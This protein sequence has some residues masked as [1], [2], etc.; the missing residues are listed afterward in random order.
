METVK[1]YY[2]NAYT[3]DFVGKV[4]SCEP[5]G[6]TLPWCWKVLTFTPKA[7]DSLRISAHWAVQR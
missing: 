6:K 4:V 7:A 2:D 5:K 1:L 3:M